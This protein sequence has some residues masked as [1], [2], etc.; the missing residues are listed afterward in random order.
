M[1]Y[2]EAIERKAR[3]HGAKWDASALDARFVRFFDSRERIK[4]ETCG[5]ILT[6]TVGM[7]T[8]WRP[9]FLLMRTRR[10]IGSAWTLSGRD[11]LLAV[12]RGRKY[13]PV[14]ARP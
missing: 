9:C 1:R 4:V 7:T 3:E 8:G 11:T 14:A 12:K 13:A 5:M 2:R 10:S 6:G